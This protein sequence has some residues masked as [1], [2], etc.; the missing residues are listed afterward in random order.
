M[1]VYSLWVLGACETP[2]TLSSQDFVRLND[3]DELISSFCS[4][5]GQNTSCATKNDGSEQFFYF[6][7]VIYKKLREW[8]RELFKGTKSSSIT[9]DKV[10][11]GRIPFT[12]LMTYFFKEGRIRCILNKLHSMKSNEYDGENTANMV[13]IDLM[14]SLGI[15]KEEV[16][17][18]V[19][20]FVYDGV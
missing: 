11:V 10:T 20:H 12:L 19:H 4:S 13:E 15:I 8:H 2:Y 6:R 3:K 9:L 1:H 14:A 5:T 18:I 16:K 7:D 17:N